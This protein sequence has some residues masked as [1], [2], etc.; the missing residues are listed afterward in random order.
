MKN[1]K[2]AR[3]LFWLQ[4]ILVRVV[5][6][7]FILPTFLT[8]IANAETIPG[9]SDV[10]YHVS[11]L[12]NGDTGTKS[13]AGTVGFQIKMTAQVNEGLFSTFR[14]QPGWAGQTGY[15]ND[16]KNIRALC[17]GCEIQ[18]INKNVFM[19]MKPDSLREMT[20]EYEIVTSGNDIS[21]DEGIY[22]AIATDTYF[23]SYGYA[24]WLM[25]MDLLGDEG[26]ARIPLVTVLSE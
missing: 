4:T 6:L 15:E 21:V 18:W 2:S 19:V 10:S 17:D 9:K 1:Q 3:I 16:F 13:D 26:D 5:G 25:P 8:P 20:I 11:L 14:I 7:S 24:L 23:H 12:K 22:R